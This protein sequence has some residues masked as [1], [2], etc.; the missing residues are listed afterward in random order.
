MCQMFNSNL[1][2]SGL[3]EMFDMINERTHALRTCLELKF[4]SLRLEKS[5]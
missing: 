4:Y 1:N 5:F 2:K 3:N